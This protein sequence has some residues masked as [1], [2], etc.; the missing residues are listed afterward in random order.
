[1]GNLHGEELAKRANEI[2]QEKIKAVVEPDHI[3]EFLVIDA[4]TGGYVFDKDDLTAAQ[5]AYSMFPNGSRFAIRIGYKAM[6]HFGGTLQR[7]E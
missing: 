2:Y 5:T 6:Y 3:G 1:M 7:T 4:D